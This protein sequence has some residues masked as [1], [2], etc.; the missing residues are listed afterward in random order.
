MWSWIEQ[1]VGMLNIDVCVDYS[2]IVEECIAPSHYQETKQQNTR[3]KEIR[4]GSCEKYPWGWFAP[5][6]SELQL[7]FISYSLWFELLIFTSWAIMVELKF[8]LLILM[9]WQIRGNDR[10]WWC[11][12]PPVHV[13]RGLRTLLISFH[14]LR[15][16]TRVDSQRFRMMRMHSILRLNDI[17]LLEKNNRKN[18][19]DDH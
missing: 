7:F 11:T 14:Q 10:Y 8:S 1:F 13:R 3:G 2:L 16:W 12:E 6:I 17:V 18:K 19:G 4:I 15:S 5:L 9:C